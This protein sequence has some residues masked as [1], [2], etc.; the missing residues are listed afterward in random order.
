[1]PHTRRIILISLAALAC[2]AALLIISLWAS[3]LPAN[4][5]GATRQSSS[6]RLRYAPSL[7]MRRTSTYRS[8]DPFP[9]VY[10]WY[11]R[12][13]SLG[14][15]QHAQGGCILM[16]RAF[17]TLWLIKEQIT[18]TACSTPNGQMMF[19]DRSSVLHYGWW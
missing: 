12:R 11:S 8:N 10:N 18:V 19:V 2:L 9:K 17:T 3:Y 4:Y 15:E 6:T 14:P 13:F 1:M 16:G 7:V 5:P